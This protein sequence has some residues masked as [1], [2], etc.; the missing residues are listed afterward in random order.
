MP[1]RRP[2]RLLAV[3]LA[4]LILALAAAASAAPVRPVTLREAA[5]RYLSGKPLHGFHAVRAGSQVKLFRNGQEKTPAGI[6]HGVPTT[7]PLDPYWP[8]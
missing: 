7:G 4:V 3:I 1:H 6:L 2:V 8:R 5:A